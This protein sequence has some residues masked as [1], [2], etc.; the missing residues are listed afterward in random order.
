MNILRQNSILSQAM[1]VIGSR[2]D[3]FESIHHLREFILEL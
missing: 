1:M 2:R 3:T